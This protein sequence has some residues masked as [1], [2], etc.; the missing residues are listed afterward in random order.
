M[1][2]NAITSEIWFVSVV[3]GFRANFDNTKFSCRSIHFCLFPTIDCCNPLAFPYNPSK[4]DT[5]I[6]QIFHQNFG[7]IA[8]FR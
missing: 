1:F 4:N 2:I 7:E 8:Q 5:D 3:K 6:S